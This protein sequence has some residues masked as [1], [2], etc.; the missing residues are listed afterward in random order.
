MRFYP[1]GLSRYRPSPLEDPPHAFLR[2]AATT[3][4]GVEIRVLAP[5]EGFA[6]P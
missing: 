2:A 6:L 5:G 3:A 4:P 1:V